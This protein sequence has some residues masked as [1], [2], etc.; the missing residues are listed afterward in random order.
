MIS[1][2]QQPLISFL[3]FSPASHA[4]S[5]KLSRAPERCWTVYPRN[6]VEQHFRRKEEEVQIT[7]LS[8]HKPLKFGICDYQVKP[9][10]GMLFDTVFGP[11]VAMMSSML[12]MVTGWFRVCTEELFQWH[13][14][15]NCLLWWFCS[16]LV[17]SSDNSNTC[18]RLLYG[19]S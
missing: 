6:V 10:L 4:L 3:F 18:V 7:G 5:F 11:S 1:K 15:S 16:A 2:K 9:V 8:S 14:T 17:S 13:Q 12:F 19:H